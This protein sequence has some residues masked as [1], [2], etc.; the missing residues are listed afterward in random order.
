MVALVLIKSW[1]PNTASADFG[2]HECDRQ[3]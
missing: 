3:S 1:Q 2:V